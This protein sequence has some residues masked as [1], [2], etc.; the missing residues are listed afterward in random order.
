MAEREQLEEQGEAPSV[1]PA[2]IFGS[3]NFLGADKRV[4]WVRLSWQDIVFWHTKARHQI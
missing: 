2:F 3:Q 4:L 1:S